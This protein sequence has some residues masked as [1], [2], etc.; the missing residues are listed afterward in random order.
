[1]LMS[2]PSSLTVGSALRILAAGKVVAIAIAGKTA[3]KAA[4]L[5]VMFR[6]N[7]C[8]IEVPVD[9]LNIAGVNMRGAY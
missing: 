8:G 6:G 7:I 5:A 3:R 1:M 9:D 4:S 2:P